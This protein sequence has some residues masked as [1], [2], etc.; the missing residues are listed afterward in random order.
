M[1]AKLL[2][3]E[4]DLSIQKVYRSVFSRSADLEVIIC[5]NDKEYYEAMELN[6]FD[7]FL[8]DLSLGQ[9]KDGIEI[10][11]EL[12]QNE[13]YKKVLIIVVSAFASKRDENECLKAGA[14][15]FL[16]KPFDSKILLNEFS[17]LKSDKLKIL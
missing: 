7:F 3:L 14:T 8:I 13:Q 12:R 10:I 16:R 15:K 2:I 5:K 1:K 11:K 6:Q 4:D 9:G 17:E